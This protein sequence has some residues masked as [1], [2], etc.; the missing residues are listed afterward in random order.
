[1]TTPDRGV[2]RNS[3]SKMLKD[4]EEWRT[5]AGVLKQ[6]GQTAAGLTLAPQDVS[7]LASQLGV[8][9]TYFEMLEKMTRL[10]REGGDFFE[11]TANRLDLIQRRWEQVEEDQSER[12]RTL[13]SKVEGV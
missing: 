13:Q 9:D 7:W 8:T 1:M 5:S 3:R 2:I 10:L 12:L 6:A 4:A 11:E